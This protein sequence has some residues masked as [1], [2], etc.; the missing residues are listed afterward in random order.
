[1]RALRSFGSTD[2]STGVQFAPS[3]GS[4]TP[5]MMAPVTTA[6]TPGRRMT[7]W[8]S[9]YQAPDSAGRSGPRRRIASFAPHS[10]NSPGAMTSAAIPATI[11]TA[12]PAMPIDCRKPSGKTVS[13]IIASATVTA[14]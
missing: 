11:A 1:M 12:A 5:I 9:R 13:V 3:D 2:V 14:L 8:E 10:A 4:A 6:T 7:A